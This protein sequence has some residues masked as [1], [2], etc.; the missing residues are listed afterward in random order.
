MIT[1]GTITI[2]A[3]AS[4]ALVDITISVRTTPKDVLVA[5][6]HIAQL[7]Q[8]SKT[9]DLTWDGTV[10]GVQVPPGDYNQFVIQ[11]TPAAETPTACSASTTTTSSWTY[12]FGFAAA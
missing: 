6:G 5:V 4:Q 10:N 12:D 9:V 1:P 7:D 3:T 2:D 11:A 8:T